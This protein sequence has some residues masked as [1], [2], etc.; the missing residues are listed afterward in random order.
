MTATC[1]SA[2]F[3]TTPVPSKLTMTRSPLITTLRGPSSDESHPDAFGVGAAGVVLCPVTAMTSSLVERPSFSWWFLGF[4]RASID[5]PPPFTSVSRAHFAHS[6]LH[7]ILADWCAP[8]YVAARYK[9]PSRNARTRCAYRLGD[10]L[11]RNPMMTGIACCC[12]CAASGHTA[13]P[14]TSVMSSRRLIVAPRGQNHTRHRLTAVRVLERGEG[15]VSCDQLFWA[16]NVGSGS[17]HPVKTGKSQ[18]QANAFRFAPEADL[19]PDLRTTPPPAFRECRHPAS[20]V[21]SQP[22][23]G[24]RPSWTV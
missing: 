24:E 23:V 5:P 10:S 2:S 20:R 15:D 7:H 6:D 22:C 3:R 17:D 21:G 8:N 11:L 16:G 12:A 19:L 13:A 1:F 18:S 4:R 9:V 14:A